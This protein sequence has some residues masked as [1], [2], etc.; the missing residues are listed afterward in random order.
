MDVSLDMIEKKNPL[1]QGL[2]RAYSNQIVDT[3]TIEKKNP[4]KQGLKHKIKHK[5]ENTRT[6]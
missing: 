6:D 1:K 3:P 4:L 5:M 2:K